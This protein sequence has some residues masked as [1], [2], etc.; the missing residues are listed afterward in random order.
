MSQAVK[1]LVGLKPELDEYVNHNLL[2]Y[3]L[4][5][6][7]PVLHSLRREKWASQ[8]AI[9]KRGS[10]PSSWRDGTFL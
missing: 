10:C 7:E 4:M 8:P 9:A 3:L 1:M 6:L 5:I 2:F